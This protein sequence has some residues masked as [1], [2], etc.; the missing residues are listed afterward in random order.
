MAG[1]PK[2]ALLGQPR[3]EGVG[4]EGREGRGDQG[5]GAICIPMA[6]EVIKTVTIL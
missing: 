6:D 3:V 4:R 1:N 2:A 5:G